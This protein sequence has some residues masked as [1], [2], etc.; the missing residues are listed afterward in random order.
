VERR[1]NSPRAA[2][3]G[4][5][6]AT[7]TFVRSLLFGALALLASG[8]VFPFTPAGREWTARSRRPFWV[9]AAGA[10]EKPGCSGAYDPAPA[11]FR[12]ACLPLENRK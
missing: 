4:I 9:V 8:L 5:S 1:L 11:E 7:W 12:E 3:G 6:N 2:G 10:S